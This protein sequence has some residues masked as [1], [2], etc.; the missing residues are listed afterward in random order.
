MKDITDV[1]K[2]QMI[3]ELQQPESDF[4]RLNYG[5]VALFMKM[6]FALL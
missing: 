3:I 1:S 6:L 5:I 2:V 4:F